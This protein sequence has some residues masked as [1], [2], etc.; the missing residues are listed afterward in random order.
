LALNETVSE[1]S[2]HTRLSWI[3]IPS[4]YSRLRRCAAARAWR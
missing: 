1:V 2:C 4:I 3:C